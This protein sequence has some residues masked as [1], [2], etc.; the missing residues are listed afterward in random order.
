MGKQRTGIL[1]V[2][3]SKNK[4]RKRRG[5]PPLNPE[6]KV[7]IIARIKMYKRLTPYKAWLQITKLK[8]F[9]WILKLHFK[10]RKGNADWWIKRFEQT[11]KRYRNKT[12]FLEKSF[13][14]TFPNK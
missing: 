13:T 7:G 12:E 2:L 9:P 14:E 6:I 4:L 5:Q 8:N 3:N 1:S 11:R 10:N